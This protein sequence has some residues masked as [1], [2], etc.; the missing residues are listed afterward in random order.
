MCL[1]QLLLWKQNS[2]VEGCVKV[3]QGFSSRLF[4]SYEVYIYQVQMN[5]YS[6]CE[7]SNLWQAPEEQLYVL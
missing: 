7:I 4:I 3:M 2:F 1:Q 5:F 6:L